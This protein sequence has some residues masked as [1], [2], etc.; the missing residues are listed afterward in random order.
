MSTPTCVHQDSHDGRYTESRKWPDADADLRHEREK[1]PLMTAHETPPD[2]STT[3]VA[4]ESVSLLLMLSP[5]LG[6]DS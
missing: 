5:G 1:H 3:T 6:V 4:S 2:K